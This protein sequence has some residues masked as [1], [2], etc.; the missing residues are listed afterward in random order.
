VRCI[1]PSWRWISNGNAKHHLCDRRWR[2]DGID[3]EIARFCAQV[4][5][6]SAS[7][8]CKFPVC[9]GDAAVAMRLWPMRRHLSSGIHS[10]RHPVGF[11]GED[12]SRGR[13]GERE[14]ILD[15]AVAMSR[16]RSFGWQ[17][18]VPGLMTKRITTTNHDQKIVISSCFIP[19]AIA[20]RQQDAR[21][22]S[23]RQSSESR[24]RQLSTWNKEDEYGNDPIE[25]P[26]AS[27]YPVIT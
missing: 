2:L 11:T 9:R 8:S 19:S 7:L 22:E 17:G 20:E 14:W 18:T 16:P 3:T 6:R 1:R 5:S 25:G 15:R 4:D 26:F 23:N 10:L 21:S 12:A 27:S 13:N 24:Q